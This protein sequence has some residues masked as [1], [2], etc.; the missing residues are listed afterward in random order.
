MARRRPP[1][2]HRAPTGGTPSNPAIPRAQLVAAI[3]QLLVG[4]RARGLQSRGAANDLF[5]FW[6]WALTLHE[7]STTL[8]PQSVHFRNRSHG[9]IRL[10]TSPGERTDSFYTYAELA[11]LNGTVQLH[12]GIYVTGISG[13]KHELDVVAVRDG[14]PRN[15]SDTTVWDVQWA[16]EAKL[17]K[18]DNG[19]PLSIPR[20]VL[21]T[22]YDIGV[23]SGYRRFHSR[24]YWRFPYPLMMLVTSTNLSHDGRTLLGPRGRSTRQTIA[25]ADSITNPGQTAAIMRFI[26]AQVSQI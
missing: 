15:Q 1:T 10:R 13:A 26:N 7:A 18:P 5:E 24:P 12:T 6:L 8:G 16:I 20:A 14:I 19:L 11:G 23:F 17:Y 3:N 22:G 21:G 25:V 2:G 9:W 4:L